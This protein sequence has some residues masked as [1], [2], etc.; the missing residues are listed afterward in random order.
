MLYCIR[1]LP[2]PY[3][4]KHIMKRFLVVMLLAVVGLQSCK[5]DDNFIFDQSPD[6]RLNAK[7]TEYQAL[8]SGAQ[9]GWK[10][11]IVTD[12]ANAGPY[13]ATYGFYFR[14]DNANRVKMYSDWNAS[15]AVTLKESSYRLKALQQP[16]L[17][18]DT[19]SYIHLL[20]DPDPDVNGGDPSTNGGLYADFEFYFDAAATDTIKL[21]G[22]FNGSKMMLVRATKQEADAYDNQQLGRG[23]LFNNIDRYLNYFKRMTVGGVVYEIKADI[24]GRTITLSWVNSSGAFQMFTTQYYYSLGGIT[25]ANPLINGSQ[26]INGFTNITWD[27]SNTTLGL[28]VNS[29]ATSIVGSGQPIRADVQAPRRW[30]QAALN[31]NEWRSGEGFHV[32]GVDDAYGIRSL[33]SGGLPF[34][35]L[36]YQSRFSGNAD[37]FGPVFIDAA[38]GQPTLFY[39]TAPTPTYTPDGRAVFVQLG[40]YSTYP[41]TGPAALTRTQ[42]YNASGYYFVQTSAT[43]YDMVSALD[44]KAWITW[45]M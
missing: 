39:G 27:A 8:L 41:A 26:T 34:F 35:Y 30:W 9:N 2:D 23:L 40:T 16:S 12:S 10:A 28:S 45:E 37:L 7:L 4:S 5:K 22:R 18:F 36:L 44:G 42:L 11:V 25:F 29:S 14:F 33:T 20:A 32:N 31:D 19:Y 6:E 21:I 38:A 15:T 17:I 24:S 3:I 43:S 13:M 1:L